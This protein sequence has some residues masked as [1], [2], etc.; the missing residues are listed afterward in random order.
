MVAA[1]GP[2][3][4]TAAPATLPPSKAPAQPNVR[5]AMASLV[6]EYPDAYPGSR[7][8]RTVEQTPSLPSNGG[9]RHPMPATDNDVPAR[10]FAGRLRFPPGCALIRFEPFNEHQISRMLDT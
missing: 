1:T 10:L 6:G 3:V 4:P 5:V 9:A 8:S 2:R 7:L